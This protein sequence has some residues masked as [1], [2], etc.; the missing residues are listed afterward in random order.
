MVVLWVIS[1][2]KEKSFSELISSQRISVYVLWMVVGAFL[3]H[4]FGG[5]IYP[6]YFDMIE[7]QFFN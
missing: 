6:E 3:T 2:T 4:I 7:E 5:D 1:R